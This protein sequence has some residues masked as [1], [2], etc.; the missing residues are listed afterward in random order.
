MFD[1]NTS[2]VTVYHYTNIFIHFSPQFQY[3]SCYCLSQAKILTYHNTTISI[4]L[5]LLF[6]HPARSR[7]L[8]KSN[9]NTSH[10]TVYQIADAKR[11][12]TNL[13]QYISC[14]CLSDHINVCRHVHAIS[15]HLMLLFI[16]NG[17]C[18]KYRNL[19]FNTSHVTV[20]R[21]TECCCIWHKLFQYI[22]CYCLSFYSK[23]M[24]LGILHFNTSHVT[25]YLFILSNLLNNLIFQYISCYCLS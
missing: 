6:I 4:H 15:I 21:D 12:S 9:F 3:I 8:Q 13:F 16:E 11:P 14:Y 25:V 10:V 20:Y 5:M 2:H 23:Y 7:H 17:H 19:Y 24:L 1:F 18:A 22:S